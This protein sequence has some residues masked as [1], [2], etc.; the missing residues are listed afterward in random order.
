MFGRLLR[1]MKLVDHGVTS[2]LDPHGEVTR[3]EKHAKHTLMQAELKCAKFGFKLHMCM[4]AR[5]RT[6]Q[7]GESGCSNSQWALCLLFRLLPGARSHVMVSRDTS[8]VHP[9]SR[10]GGLA[11][12]HTHRKHTSPPGTEPSATEGESDWRRERESE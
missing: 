1:G 6:G 5:E 11:A 4:E 2:N 7:W 12:K 10:G 9:H 3:G 8:V